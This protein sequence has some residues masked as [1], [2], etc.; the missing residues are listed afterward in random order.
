MPDPDVFLFQLEALAIASRL[1]RYD[2]HDHAEL[3]EDWAHSA[4][5]IRQLTPS[6]GLPR[7]SSI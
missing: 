3:V 4:D 7:H 5:L 2:Q 6:A 1:R